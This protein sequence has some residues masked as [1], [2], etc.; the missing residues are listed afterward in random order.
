MH[1][2]KKL[3][4]LK[5]SRN[6]TLASIS[7]ETGLSISYVSDIMNERSRPSLEALQK[8]TKAFDVSISY[9]LEDR[10]VTYGSENERRL[11]ELLAD[12]NSWSVRDQLELL[13][14]IAAKKA[15]LDPRE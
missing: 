13:D 3:K 12:F 1:V 10:A 11:A 9:V 8:L 7:D 2:G 4:E 15:H 5:R 6:K 14:L